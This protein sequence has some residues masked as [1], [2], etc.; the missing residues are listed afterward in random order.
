MLTFLADEIARRVDERTSERVRSRIERLDRAVN[1]YGYDETGFS[2]DWLR[3]LLSISSYLY[4]HYFRVQTFGIANIPEGRVILAG[5]HS[6]Q[7]AYDGLLIITSLLL[8]CEPPRHAVGM[9]GHFFF[10]NPG[11]SQLMPR[12]GQLNGTK[13]N[14]RH[15]LARGDAVMIFPEGEAGGGKTLFNKYALMPFK[16]GFMRLA[17]ET[18]TPIVPFG[19]VGGE[20]M[21]PSFSRME[22]FAKKLGMPYMTLSPTGPLPLPTRCSIHYGEPLYFEGDPSDEARVQ[23]HVDL[24]SQ[25][26]RDLLDR[27][28]SQRESIF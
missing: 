20:E 13:E 24:V 15:V 16:R 25:K 9:A 19:F 23:S 4:E 26:V 1:E 27:G 10:G 8:E 17:L 11:Y 22:S 7:M 12:I 14:C 2:K 21:V 18:H 6:S 5:N 28:L 3:R